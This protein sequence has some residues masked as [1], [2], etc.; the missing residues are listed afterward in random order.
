MFGIG[1]RPKFFDKMA[2]SAKTVAAR[3]KMALRKKSGLSSAGSQGRGSTD[4]FSN[5]S[6]TSQENAALAWDRSDPRAGNPLARRNAQRA[7]PFGSMGNRADALPGVSLRGG[8]QRSGVPRA[9]G[10]T[11]FDANLL[12]QLSPLERLA[13]S[14]RAQ[15]KAAA[16]S[17]PA[18]SAS[19]TL[20][21]SAD[22]DVD[23][24]AK[25]G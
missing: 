18:S 13:Q 16:T 11:G 5:Q 15:Q 12:G 4:S 2:Q 22:I 9:L 6:D 3:G 24:W 20:A 23:Q 10:A 17:S 1:N 19:S 14:I 21:A 25:Y 7:Q 8:S